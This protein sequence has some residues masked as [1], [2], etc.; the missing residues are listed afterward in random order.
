MFQ[1]KHQIG[2][3]GKISV[4]FKEGMVWPLMAHG[5]MVMRHLW[6][7]LISWW[8]HQMETFSALLALCAGNSPGTGEFPTQ[9]LVTQ[10]FDVFFDLR[11]NKLLSK[12]SWGWWF[13]TLPCPLWRHSNG[14]CLC[15]YVE[16][17][18]EGWVFNAK[19]C[20]I[21]L[22]QIILL[23]SK[24]KHLHFTEPIKISMSHRSSHLMPKTW[25]LKW[26][27]F[28]PMA[29]V[30]YTDVKWVLLH[31]KSLADCLFVQQHV[32]VNLTE[33]T[34]ALQ[35]WPFVKWIHRSLVDF[36]HKRT[37]IPPQRDS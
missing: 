11:L 32:Q 2:M 15:H 33:N 22:K 3:I 36:L 24:P 37:V 30:H 16:S 19:G 13:E 26:I 17:T 25:C 29:S 5:S 12:Q 1:R 31:L 14:A 27:Y 34:K 20:I 6:M 10:S 7:Q 21:E 35:Y 23:N 28:S 18:V 4:E 9:R 8:R